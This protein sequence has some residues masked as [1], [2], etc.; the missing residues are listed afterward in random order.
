VNAPDPSD[1]LGALSPLDGRYADRVGEFAAA[2]SE[3]ALIRHRFKV[4]VEWLLALASHPGIDELAPWPPTRWPSCGAGSAISVGT[5][6]C[7]SSRSRRAP[8]TT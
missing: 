2:F 3:E 1:R 4:E 8:T 7:G 6:R 5:M